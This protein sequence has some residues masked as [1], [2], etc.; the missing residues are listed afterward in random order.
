MT[1]AEV[2]ALAHTAVNGRADN[3]GPP[4]ENFCV[5]ADLWSACLR[6]KHK[7]TEADVAL[8]MACLKIARLIK[9]PRHKDSWVD[10]AGFAA[11]G[12]E[13]CAHD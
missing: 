10:L 7:F 11:C 5:I 8:M 6:G 4:A 2:L 12:G 9:N 13:A 3:Y 1:R